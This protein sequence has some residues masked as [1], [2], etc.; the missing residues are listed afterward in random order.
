MAVDTETRSGVSYPGPLM[1]AILG[2]VWANKQASFSGIAR[3][4]ASEH[5]PVAASTLSTTLTR[6]VARGWIIRT[7]YGWYEAGI[8]RDELL[9]MATEAIR[10]A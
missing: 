10:E 1:L 9:A 5:R 4:V 8:S 3:R 2:A 7:A 6:L